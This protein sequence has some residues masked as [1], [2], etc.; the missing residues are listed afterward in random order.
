[1][2]IRD[3]VG[4]V[5]LHLELRDE[6]ARALEHGASPEPRARGERGLVEAPERDVLRHAHAG[7]AGV[8][9][10]L[11]GQAEGAEG[12]DLAAHR[13]IRLAVHADL[14]GRMV[15]CLLYTS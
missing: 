14:A 10:R 2:C 9:E 4:S 12:A 13:V 1:M 8:P 3:S 6:A 5:G 7:H 11:F 15:P